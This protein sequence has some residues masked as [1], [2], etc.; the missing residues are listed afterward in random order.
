VIT[1]ARVRCPY[2]S[3]GKTYAVLALIESGFANQ[4]SPREPARTL[5]R[6]AIKV[7]SPAPVKLGVRAE[8]IKDP[9]MVLS[10]SLSDI[11]DGGNTPT[12]TR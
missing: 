9:P 11:G 4:M 1:E 5:S 2:E 10:A 12:G 8:K 7:V 3:I 6:A